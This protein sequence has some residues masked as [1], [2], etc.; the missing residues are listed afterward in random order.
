MQQFLLSIIYPMAHVDTTYMFT[1][2]C[3]ELL[4][5]P[6]CRTESHRRNVHGLHM[7]SESS[8]TDFQQRPM[9]SS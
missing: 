5:G 1:E 6:G 3:V 2:F 7:A 8:A 9:A 4:S